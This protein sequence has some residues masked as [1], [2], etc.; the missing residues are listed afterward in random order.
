MEST[1]LRLASDISRIIWG[2]VIR[3]FDPGN[4]DIPLA[5][6]AFSYSTYHYAV[7]DILNSR[8]LEEDVRDI[9]IPS[10]AFILNINASSPA[11]GVMQGIV[12]NMVKWMSEEKYDAESDDGAK[13]ILGMKAQILDNSTLEQ[14]MFGYETSVL[15][16]YSYVKSVKTLREEIKIAIFSTNHEVQYT[17]QVPTTLNKTTTEH[18][19]KNIESNGNSVLIFFVIMA[20]FISIILLILFTRP[21]TSD[22]KP[23]ISESHAVTESSTTLPPTTA[24]TKP[25]PKPQSRP[26][27]GTISI[28]TVST[29]EITSEI[30]VHTSSQDCVVKLKTSSGKTVLSF[31]VRANDTVTIGVPA[32][33]LYAYFAQGDTWYGWSSYFGESTVYSKD[34]SP[35][36]FS[37]YTIDY[38]LYRVSNGNL[39]L[40][41]VDEDDF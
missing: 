30:T 4:N 33:V 36:D 19:S 29:E 2:Y 20:A 3:S 12:N 40:T 5:E 27:S 41:P 25:V 22:T 8:G 23:A 28:N 15:E 26:T 32:R 37:N 10:A 31:F 11:L 18:D 21:S 17:K 39:S 14:R 7:I 16:R 9:F 35:T 24:A 1:N 13:K 34:S 38:T 6:V